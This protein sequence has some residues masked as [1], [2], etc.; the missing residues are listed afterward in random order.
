M[1]FGELRCRGQQAA[2]R[3]LDEF[4]PLFG[5][6]GEA[7]PQ[8]LARGR[9]SG[10]PAQ[11]LA[12][13]VQG[14]PRRFFAGAAEEGLVD[15]LRERFPDDCAAT[16][17]AAQR[18]LDGRFDLLGYHDLDF[19][20]PPDWHLDPIANRRAPLV[21]WRHVN[22]LDPA[23]V[24]D[25]KVIWELN[26][27][28]WFVTL[29]QAYQLPGDETYATAVF[30]MIDAWTIENPWGIGINWA[31]SLEVALR[32]IAWCWTLVLLRESRALTPERFLQVQRLA[33]AHATHIER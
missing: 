17:T 19:G 1:S 33:C 31:S 11:A 7:R 25:S 5:P 21:H 27:H 10:R 20:T 22:P 6:A 30:E 18:V 2:T 4:L 23:V 15:L 9:R 14:T 32:L 8:W 29:A 3:W 28:Q 16:L 26:R 12:R 24:G 13:F